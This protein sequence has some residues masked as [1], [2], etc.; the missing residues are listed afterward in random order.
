[1]ESGQATVRQAFDLANRH[2]VHCRLSKLRRTPPP[3]ITQPGSASPLETPPAPIENPSEKLR[4]L[5]QHSI[6]QLEGLRRAKSPHLFIAG[7]PWGM[8]G[9]VWLAFCG[10]SYAALGGN[11]W[12][13]L[14]IGSVLAVAAVIAGGIWLHRK[15]VAV[16][17]PPYQWLYDSLTGA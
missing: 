15:A 6:A 2:L 3:V 1:I 17:T 10:A 16:A 14:P 11:G 9:L 4:D 8:A 13:W 5:A 7:K 12:L